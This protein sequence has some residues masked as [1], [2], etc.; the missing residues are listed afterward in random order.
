MVRAIVQTVFALVRN[1]KVLRSFEGL[2]SVKA[3]FQCG[4]PLK[5]ASALGCAPSSVYRAIDRLEREIGAPLFDRNSAGW[6]PTELGGR[7]LWLAERVE[8]D[9]LATELHL[10]GRTKSYPSP[11]RI[12]ASDSLANAY[13][14]PVIAALMAKSPDIDIELIADNHFADLSR[15]EA[16]IAIRPDKAPG[17]QL[18]G[19]RAGK[20]QH[21][22]YA[23]RALL[24][25]LGT[26]SSMED[27][28]RYPLCSLSS[29]L[30]HFSAASWLRS[31][32]A[33]QTARV[34]FTANSEMGLAGAIVGGAGIGMLP[35]FLGDDLAGVSRIPIAIGEPVDIWI[36][37]H[38]TLRDNEVVRTVVRALAAAIRSDA[39]RFSGDRRSVD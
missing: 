30:A 23:A 6:I 4:T 26:P 13:L 25:R 34:A 2:A 1:M 24:E 17:E 14:G 12:S 35:C 10:L 36:V 39:G 11:V 18:I 3:T 7:V 33:M 20:L 9:V 31:D 8:Q 27:L 21:R 15:R 28:A 29:K 22:L 16:D 32:P 38:P 19:R 5:A 37:T